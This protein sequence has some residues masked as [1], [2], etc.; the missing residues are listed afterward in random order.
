MAPLYPD[1]SPF[2]THRR[3]LAAIVQDD[4][5]IASAHAGFH[6]TLA[7]WW[8]KNHPPV[9]ALAPDGANK[10]HVD[11]LRRVLLASIGKTFATHDSVATDGT[12]SSAQAAQKSARNAQSS[13]PTGHPIPAQSSAPWA[14]T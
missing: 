6:L 12:L 9:I 8:N 3:D 13:A 4:P 10:G 7:K 11:Q 5:A 14:S 2:I 1:F